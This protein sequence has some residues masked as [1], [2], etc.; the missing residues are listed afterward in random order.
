MTKIDSSEKYV[1]QAKSLNKAQADYLISRIRGEFGRKLNNE[2]LLNAL[3][4]Q[5]EQE[6]ED[7]QIW[8]ERLAEIRVIY[9]KYGLD[10]PQ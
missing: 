9:E 7:L 8:R 4:M 1:Q 10:Q 5:L 2:E 3:A 6:D